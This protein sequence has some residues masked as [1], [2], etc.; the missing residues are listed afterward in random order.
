MAGR[1]HATSALVSNSSIICVLEVELLH[2]C[3]TGVH[4]GHVFGKGLPRLVMVEA[5]GAYDFGV[6]VLGLDVP[7]QVGLVA[8]LRV[9]RHAGPLARD[10]LH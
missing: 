4:L 2:E 7:A 6:D 1:I 10:L 3:D 5:D 8:A 9:A